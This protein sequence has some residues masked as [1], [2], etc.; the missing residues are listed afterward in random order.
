MMGNIINQ[1]IIIICKLK[2]LGIN[3][4][5]LHSKILTGSGIYLKSVYNKHIRCKNISFKQELYELL[6]L[7]RFR[8][9]NYHCVK[10]NLKHFFNTKVYDDHYKHSDKM[11]G[12]KQRQELLSETLDYI[13]KRYYNN[14]KNNKE[15]QKLVYYVNSVLSLDNLHYMHNT[16]R[17]FVVKNYKTTLLK[18]Y[19]TNFNEMNSKIQ[20]NIRILKEIIDHV[21]Y[22]NFMNND[23]RITDKIEYMTYKGKQINVITGY[24]YT[25][26]KTDRLRMKQTTDLTGY[27]MDIC[28]N[29]YD[30]INSNNETKEIM[31][32]MEIKQGKINN[33]LL[34][35]KILLLIQQYKESLY[36][37]NFGI[38]SYN[39]E[40]K[41][42]TEMMGVLP[43]DNT[44]KFTNS[45]DNYND[46]NIF[47]LY[48]KN[49]SENYKGIDGKTYKTGYKARIN[50][51]FKDPNLELLDKGKSEYRKTNKQYITYKARIN[52][53]LQQRI[54]SFKL[55][56]FKHIKQ[57]KKQ[58]INSN[59]QNIEF[60]FD[61]NN[62]ASKTYKYNKYI[63]NLGFKRYMKNYMIFLPHYENK[64]YLYCSFGHLMN[65][66]HDPLSVIEDQTKLGNLKLQNI[67]R[68]KMNTNIKGFI[69]YTNVLIK[70][71]I[72]TNLKQL[73]HLK[74]KQTIKTTLIKLLN[75]V[76][77]INTINN[78][79]RQYFISLMVEIKTKI[80]LR[81]GYYDKLLI[82]LQ[83]LTASY[84]NL[85]SKRTKHAK[86]INQQIKSLETKMINQSNMI[87]TLKQQRISVFEF[88]TRIFNR[89]KINDISD[90]IYNVFI[91]Q[92][93]YYNTK[94]L[95]RYVNTQRSKIELLK[96]GI[97]NMNYDAS[98]EFN[99]I[100][101][102]KDNNKIEFTYDNKF[103][104]LL[105]YTQEINEI[106]KLSDQTNIPIKSLLKI[107]VKMNYIYNDPQLRNKLIDSLY[108][109]TEKLQNLETTI[110]NT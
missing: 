85:D 91:T 5:Q 73:L 28:N 96:L 104:E 45:F 70:R 59:Y 1:R 14:N 74:N 37:M 47:I 69:E 4:K 81:N 51:I 10:C 75:H 90:L 89:I 2:A 78:D 95:V 87:V 98:I 19:N 109:V 77:H 39:K 54:N 66:P 105:D 55:K 50:Q 108:K 36:E 57:T 92:I 80:I 76:M 31:D 32:L 94:R 53:E 65:P 103:E 18:H 79:L 82:K 97:N 34:H 49:K 41:L 63:K 99:E 71:G 7:K 84:L 102:L 35:N 56:V 67:F 30:L 58:Q 11:F 107:C 52:K 100:T 22:I 88:Y 60:K 110:L 26:N 23:I 17:S 13:I 16:L 27:N 48:C 83:I 8:I 93:T 15:L 101:Y 33:K 3:D 38:K 43:F 61:Y 25:N 62:K 68:E 86:H 9:S 106:N 12:N 40:T 24:N 42:G 46:L 20:R 29:L 6:N 64:E 44:G 21:D 72:K